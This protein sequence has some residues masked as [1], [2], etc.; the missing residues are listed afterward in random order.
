[1][2]SHWKSCKKWPHRKVRGPPQITKNNH[3]NNERDHRRGHAAGNKSVSAIEQNVRK[4]ESISLAL[5][6]L[7]LSQGRNDI[8]HLLVIIT[9]LDQ[10]SF[11]FSQV[12]RGNQSLLLKTKPYQFG[13]G[14]T[15]M[16]FLV[17]QMRKLFVKSGVD[18]FVFWLLCNRENQINP[19]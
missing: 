2:S 17:L 18:F 16:R 14:M 13:H 5:V 6:L 7:R 10:W 1:M 3:N 8:G 12:F 11:E 19:F 15:W 4:T 9:P